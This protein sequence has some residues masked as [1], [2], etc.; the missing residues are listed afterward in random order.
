MIFAALY[1][2]VMTHILHRKKL[3]D[4]DAEYLTKITANVQRSWSRPHSASLFW[5]FFLCMVYI[6]ILQKISLERDRLQHFCMFA[7]ILVKYS[8]P[9]WS[10]FF[11][12]KI[13]IITNS[14]GKAN[15]IWWL[16][17]MRNRGLLLPFV[18][19]FLPKCP[20]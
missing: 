12:C 4:V 18:Y 8:A 2:L 16:Y 17:W 1:E 6:F 14:K 20:S 11:L 15:I 10:N 3:D 9:M 7:V 19:P 5:A 13:W